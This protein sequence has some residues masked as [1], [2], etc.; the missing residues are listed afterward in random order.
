M[1]AIYC[2]LTRQH[3][4]FRGLA[5]L[6]VPTNTTTNQQQMPAAVSSNITMHKS[7]A[8]HH[9]IHSNQPL[10]CSILL[11]RLFRLRF[12]TF[13][14]IQYGG[15]YFDEGYFALQ[16]SMSTKFVSQSKASVFTYS[17]ITFGRVG[18]G[19][20]AEKKQINRR[21][22]GRAD[23]TWFRRLKLTFTVCGWIITFVKYQLSRCPLLTWPC[24]TVSRC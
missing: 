11:V 17:N 24:F 14:F 22:Q 16:G 19:G 7:Q 3:C 20:S 8:Q 23:L 9:C 12:D 5:S 1:T 21:S 15:H 6:L 2:L 13:I 10:H 4:S 18:F